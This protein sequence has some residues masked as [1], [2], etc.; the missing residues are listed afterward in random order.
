MFLFMWNSTIEKTKC[1]QYQITG[2]LGEGKL[3]AK[4]KMF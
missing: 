2:C 1:D 4:E 3:A